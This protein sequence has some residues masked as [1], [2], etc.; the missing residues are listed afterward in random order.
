MV[1][2]VLFLSGA[3]ADARLLLVAGIALGIFF[4][5]PFLPIYTRARSRVYRVVK[6]TALIGAVC[7]AFGP[8]PLKY[9]WLLAP[10]AWTP[11][12]IEWQRATVRRKLPMAQWPRQLYL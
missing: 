12:W 10:C 4:A 3:V 7:L 1:S 5:A 11:L 8:D 2:P 6:W 9:I